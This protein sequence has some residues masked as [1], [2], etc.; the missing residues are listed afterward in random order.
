MGF[1]ISSVGPA[2][3]K[4]VPST[5]GARAQR[6][7][8]ARAADDSVKVDAIPSSPPP[9]VQAAMGVAADA[10]EKLK[11]TGRQLS[12]QIDDATGKLHIE[13]HDLRGKVLFTVP[14]SKALDVASG[15][16]LD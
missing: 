3:A 10:Y 15:G 14:P 6:S 13:V 1:N 5:G 9:E 16:S 11:A 7:A 4:Q 12:F 2:E 8:P